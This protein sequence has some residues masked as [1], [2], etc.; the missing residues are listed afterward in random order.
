[1]EE[2]YYIEEQENIL[3]PEDVQAEIKHTRHN[4]ELLLYIICSILGFFCIFYMLIMSAVTKSVM[5]E[6]GDILISP[7]IP[8]YIRTIFV[9][10]SLLSGTSMI[11]F[12][13]VVTIL[14]LYDLYS[15]NMSYAIRV[16]ENNFPEIY[17]KVQEYT[18]L[19]GLK[20]EPEVY[21]RQQNGVVNAYSAWIP[22]KTFIQLNAEIV[23]IAYMEHEDLNTVLFVM[24]H[25]M[26]H[27]YL[28]HVQ[29]YYNILAILVSFVP[30]VG[31]AILYPLLSRAREY[32]CD[33]VAQALTNNTNDLACI[34][35]LAGGRHLYKYMDAEK[36]LEDINANH[37]IVE[38]FFRWLANLFASH[39]IIPFRT[40]AIIDPFKRSGRLL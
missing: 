35:M 14:R 24:A 6:V 8:G 20:K 33:R 21:V 16:S 11:V 19:L 13:L 37:N 23:D 30:I 7:E 26:G 3:R 25:E 17:E 12:L 32:S 5:N 34:M 18:Y 38:R 29:I 15:S 1:M 10:L 31:P 2:N 40:Q 22:G 4:K 27:I 28:H 39:P 36:Y 9:M